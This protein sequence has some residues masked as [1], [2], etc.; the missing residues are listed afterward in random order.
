MDKMIENNGI[1]K[2]SD[3]VNI[4][5]TAILQSQARAVKAVYQEQLAWNDIKTNS[6]VA[7][8]ELASALQFS[9]NESST[10]RQLQ[11]ANLPYSESSFARVQT[12]HMQNTSCKI[13]ANP[14]VSQPTKPLTK[15]MKN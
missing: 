15:W 3:A 9:D 8:D 6:S 5:K 7:T 1:L 13:S 11:L 2:T 4:L 14:Q 10:I 12:K